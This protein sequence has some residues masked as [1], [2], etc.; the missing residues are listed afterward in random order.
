MKACCFTGHRPD[1]L[2]KV[3]TQAHETLLF[4]LRRTVRIAI[5]HGVT[6]F[7]A[8]GAQG[9]D[10]LAAEAVLEVKKTHPEVRLILAL[11]GRDQADRWSTEAKQRYRAVLIE[12]D[13]VWYA[14]ETTATQSLFRRNR[15]LVDHADCCVAYLNKMSGGTY[16][17]VQYALK[18][19]RYI[20]NLANGE[21]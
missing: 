21:T 20:I 13:E 19:N 3:G 15:Y 8:G 5:E 17:T 10:Q 12:A 7:L 4:Q 2:P 6:T 11:P 14:A 18:A 16:Y 1:A 9:F